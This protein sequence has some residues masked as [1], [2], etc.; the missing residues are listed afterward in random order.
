M[1]RRETLPSN[2]DENRNSDIPM[3]DVQDPATPRERMRATSGEPAI[4]K[5]PS[6]TPR[7][8]KDDEDDT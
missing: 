6:I 2:E 4:S 5:V 1:K 3:P 7:M 8:L